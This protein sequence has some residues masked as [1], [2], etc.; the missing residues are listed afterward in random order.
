MACLGVC[1]Y[2][3]DI[4]CFVLCWQSISYS[5]YVCLA[6]IMCL[7]GCCFLLLNVDCYKRAICTILD[8]SFCK[9]HKIALFCTKIT[10]FY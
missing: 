5:D 3:G 10:K 6:A 8:C 1:A 2:L 7:C 9:L 4:E